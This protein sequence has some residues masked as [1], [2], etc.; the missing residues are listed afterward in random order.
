MVGTTKTNEINQAAASEQLEYLSGFG[1]EHYSQ[2]LPGALPEGRF[3]PQ[4]VAF[5][6]YAEKFSA[7][8]FTA[9]RA[10]FP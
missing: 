7:T 3:S 9:P 1:N 4:K 2:A 8:A 10:K 6:L 5:G